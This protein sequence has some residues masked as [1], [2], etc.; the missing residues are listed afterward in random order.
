MK[1]QRAINRDIIK[2]IAILAVCAAVVAACGYVIYLTIVGFR[3][4]TVPVRLVAGI[5][6]LAIAIFT[7][8]TIINFTNFPNI[9]ARIIGNL[10]NTQNSYERNLHKKYNALLAQY[11]FA[12]YKFES[13]CWKMEPR[14]TTYEI[15]EMALKID[16]AEW[17][18]REDAAKKN[19]T[20]K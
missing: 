4:T 16:E 20:V 8:R 14:P 18:R 11:P 17:A 12:I 7:L 13:D 15:I 9:W 6:T 3:A 2:V 10:R 5:I 19:L 1:I